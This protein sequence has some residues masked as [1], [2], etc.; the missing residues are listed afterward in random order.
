MAG[1]CAAA[2]SRRKTKGK[3]V[4]PCSSSPSDKLK[5]PAVHLD[6][7]RCEIMS[8]H[9]MSDRQ[10]TKIVRPFDVRTMPKKPPAPWCGGGGRR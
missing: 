8:S 9:R 3:L 4:R 6:R 2:V 1:L 7:T 10:P 5:S